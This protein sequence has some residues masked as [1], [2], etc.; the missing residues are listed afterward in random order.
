MPYANS[1]SSRT[2]GLVGP[3]SRVYCC[4]PERR[5]DAEECWEGLVDGR[6]ASR[7][8][9]P[10]SATHHNRS[11]CPRHPGGRIR[12]A[13]SAMSRVPRRPRDAPTGSQPVRRLRRV[14][15]SGPP[16]QPREVLPCRRLADA[17]LVGRGRDR[18]GRD[19]GPQH[20][21]LAPGRPLLGLIRPSA[22]RPARRSGGPVTFS[23]TNRGL[24]E[25]WAKLALPL[26]PRPNPPI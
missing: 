5:A 6:R 14:Q 13:V 11:E 25:R 21:E 16:V 9:V 22:R 23:S 26:S 20:L 8:F 18:A 19:V 1:F 10:G 12:H 17:Q 15:A 3:G 4:P 2:E 7:D 24:T